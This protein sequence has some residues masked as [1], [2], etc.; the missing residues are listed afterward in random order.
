METKEIIEY[1]PK[2]KVITDYIAVEKT[3]EYQ[4]QVV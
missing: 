1:V 4:P 3:I 2:Y